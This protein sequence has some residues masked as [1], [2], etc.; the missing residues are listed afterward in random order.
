MS[1]LIVDDI[2]FQR[3]HLRE[4][5]TKQFQQFIPV[6]E[7]EHGSQATELFQESKPALVIL[8]I[9]L[10]GLNG[11]KVAQNLWGSL[12]LTRILFW[13]QYKDEAYLRQLCKIVPSETVYG[14]V[15]KTSPDMKLRQA[16]NALLV[17]EQ[18]WIDPEVRGIQGQSGS[19]DS[20]LTDAEY[21]ALVDISLGL[22]DKTIARRRYLSERGVQNR[23]REVY[24][25]LKVDVDQSDQ[26]PWGYIFGAR[27]RAVCVAVRRGLIN[28]EE[29]T[30]E[31][32]ELRHW[33]AV[34]CGLQL[35]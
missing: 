6:L 29:L 34:Q 20:G 4:L 31:D 10:P 7:A 18:C 15:L 1:I 27:A 2:S 8:D 5:L 24:R 17:E 35:N 25:K 23:L 28:S 16:V 11:I 9:K 30:R 26:P 22:T 14:Y 12:P 19:K 3:A 21:E 13:S 33:L 32:E